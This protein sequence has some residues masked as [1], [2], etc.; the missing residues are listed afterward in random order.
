MSKGGG[1]GLVA[2]V[3]SIFV[4]LLTSGRRSLAGQTLTWVWREAGP[5]LPVPV[6]A[7][8]YILWAK[9]Q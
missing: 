1:R 4:N 5:R 9:S 3:L 8:L 6:T 7:S 2:F